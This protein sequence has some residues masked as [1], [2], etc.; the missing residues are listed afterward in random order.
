M[1]L[2]LC[3][4]ALGLAWGAGLRVW[5][6]VLAGDASRYTWPGTVLGVLLPATL[7]GTTLGWAEQARRT[8]GRR[9]WRWTALA[10]LLFVTMLA[11]VLDDVLALLRSGLGTGAIGTALIG[12]LGGY[13]LSG[14]GTGWARTAARTAMVLLVVAALVGTAVSGPGPR[15]SAPSRE[16][17]LLALTLLLMLGLLAWACAIPHL[18][19]QREA[20][21]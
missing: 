13:A 15:L 19:V 12:M 20:A 4:A 1:R 8:G 21:L 11:L 5:M 2:T 10:P 16:Q 3:G 7:V 9:G 17:A 14:R 18:P 6:A